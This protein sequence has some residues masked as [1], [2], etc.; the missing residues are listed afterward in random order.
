MVDFV[1]WTRTG[2]STSRFQSGRV[3]IHIR[4]VYVMFTIRANCKLILLYH[5]S[6]ACTS[7]LWWCKK[8]ILRMEKGYNLFGWDRMTED[9]ALQ[10]IALYGP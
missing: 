1:P 5:E 4:D 3:Y 10:F 8:F 6:W 2:F 7:I 9:I